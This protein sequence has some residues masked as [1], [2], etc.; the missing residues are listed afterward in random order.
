VVYI[1]VAKNLKEEKKMYDGDETDASTFVS[2]ETGRGP[3]GPGWQKSV[4]N[5]HPF[6][7]YSEWSE[8]LSCAPANLMYKLNPKP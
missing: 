1:D 3:L 2:K 6:A 4:R 5:H 8:C 7:L